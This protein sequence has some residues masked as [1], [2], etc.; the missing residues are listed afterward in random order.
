MTVSLS[1][2]T[3]SEI[4]G[5]TASLPRWRPRVGARARVDDLVDHDRPEQLPR[6]SPGRHLLGYPPD[7][8]AAVITL[9]G[10]RY[11]R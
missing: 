3:F 1:V 9:T 11:D 10:Q 7:D 2:R 5:R 4:T 8:T 6:G